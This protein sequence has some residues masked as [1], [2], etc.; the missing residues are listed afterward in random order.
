M[1]SAL[2]QVKLGLGKLNRYQNFENNKLCTQ[3]LS[4]SLQSPVA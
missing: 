4:P 2:I 3:E 1:R